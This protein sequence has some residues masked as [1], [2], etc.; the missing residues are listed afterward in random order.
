MSF[1]RRCFIAAM[2]CA[3]V[4]GWPVAR[5]ASTRVVE[6]PATLARNIHLGAREGRVSVGLPPTHVAFSWSGPESS[7]LRYR[8]ISAG[9]VSRWREVRESEEMETADRHFSAVFVVDR[10]DAIEW[11]VV[12]GP[13]DA[14]TLHEMNTIDGPRRTIEAPAGAPSLASTPDIVTRAEWGADETIKRTSGDCARRFFDV[15]QL[16][17]HHTAGTNHDPNPPA[18]MR[19]IYWYHV[20]SRGWCDIGYNFVIGSDGRIYEARWARNYKPWEIH[21]SENSNGQGVVGAHVAGFNSG[22]IGMSLMGNYENVELPTTMR[23]SLVELLAWEA[24]RHDL[25][26]NESHM[27]RNPDTGATR[28]LPYIAGHRDAGQTACPGRNVYSD[29]KKIRTEVAAMVGTGR[30]AAQVRLWN[31]ADTV[32]FGE[33][34]V[35]GG[36]LRDQSGASLAGRTVTL[37]VRGVGRR[38]AQKAQAITGTDGRFSFTLELRR[39]SD[40]IVTFAGDETAWE[41]D[42]RPRRIGVRPLVTLVPEGG[43][44]GP[45]GVYH[46]DEAT[47]YI[48]FSGDVRPRH[49]GD[50]VRVRVS[51]LRK[52]GSYRELVVARRILDSVGAYRYRFALP[53]RSSGTYRAVARFHRDA[54][55]L[56]ASSPRVDFVVS[57]K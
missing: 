49:P 51:K 25:P 11:E 12:R 9:V 47:R 40:V 24:D 33:V 27:Y 54:D 34:T 52:D 16:F 35:L 15:Q 36:R 19:A 44:T 7:A 30:T 37:Y 2:V 41:D 31:A 8:L 29:L 57:A 28:R 13:V 10:P 18:T 1:S 53:A 4:S 14:V 5:A 3:V 38:W 21:D 43:D 22:S 23:D 17:V 56:G 32:D 26:A 6:V 46:F 20:R 55:H 50:L 42:S 48:K 39:T 45:D